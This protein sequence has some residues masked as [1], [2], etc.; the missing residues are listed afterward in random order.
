MIADGNI[1]GWFKAAW[2]SDRVRS[3]ID[4]FLQIP[5]VP[6]RGD[7]QLK[8]QTPR[9]LSAVRAEHPGRTRGRLVR[10][11]AAFGEPRIH[12]VRLSDKAR[13]W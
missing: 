6:I 7:S 5:A 8:N 10:T 2:S 4:H 12:A 3:A 13:S 1:V 9:G 11:R